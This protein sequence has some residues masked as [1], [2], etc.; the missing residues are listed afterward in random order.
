MGNLLLKNI[1]Y[2][3]ACDAQPPRHTHSS[4]KIVLNQGI[5][6]CVRIGIRSSRCR[7]KTYTVGR[8]AVAE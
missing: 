8:I 7:T 2:G 3:K 4:L 1:L 6:L 5:L